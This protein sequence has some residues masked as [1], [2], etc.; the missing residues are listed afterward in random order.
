VGQWLRSARTRF[1]L[2]GAYFA[3]TGRPQKRIEDGSAAGPFITTVGEEL[4]SLVTPGE[5]RT[6]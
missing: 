1:T 6:P 4:V 5:R 3:A 2:R